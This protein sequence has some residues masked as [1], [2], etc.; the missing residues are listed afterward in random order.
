[1]N[2]RARFSLSTA[3]VI[4]VGAAA[5]LAAEAPG[6]APARVVAPLVHDTTP[7]QLFNGRTI[8]S[9]NIV[10]TPLPAAKDLNAP[11]PPRP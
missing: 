4:A 11:L 3:V 9:R 8:D 7:I 6:L 10:L 1:M 2:T 5:T